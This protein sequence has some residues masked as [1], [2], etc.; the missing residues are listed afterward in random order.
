MN[1]PRVSTSLCSLVSLEIHFP[2]VTA[3]C[4]RGHC[5]HAASPAPVKFS[6]VSGIANT[7]RKCLHCP[8][9]IL[10]CSK[11]GPGLPEGERAS[12]LGA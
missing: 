3:V 4:E 8:S 7:E 12:L 2:A 5:L 1:I 11:L 10:V 6:W 9:L